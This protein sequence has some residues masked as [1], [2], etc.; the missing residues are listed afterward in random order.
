MLLDKTPDKPELAFCKAMVSGQLDGGFQPELGLT[1]GTADMNVHS[2]FFTREKMET[3]IL[4]T[5][6][7][8]AHVEPAILF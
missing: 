8:R 5:K 2:W 4:I 3:E 7:R 6:N 1:V